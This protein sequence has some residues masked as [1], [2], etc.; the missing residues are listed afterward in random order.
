MKSSPGIRLFCTL[1]GSMLLC[2][3]AAA[4]SQLSPS[5]EFQQKT[6]PYKR[7]EFL[8]PAESE[9]ETKGPQQAARVITLNRRQSSDRTLDDSSRLLQDIRRENEEQNRVNN[10]WSTPNLVAPRPKELVCDG[11]MCRE[12]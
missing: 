3:S 8:L 2:A 7:P 4:Q 1:C 5:E 9:W 11:A 10:T 12:K 6:A